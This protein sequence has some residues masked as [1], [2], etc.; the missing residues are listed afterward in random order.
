MKINPSQIQA[1]RNSIDPLRSPVN[2]TVPQGRKAERIGG[3]KA[4]SDIA[5]S[6][7]IDMLSRAEKQFLAERFNS[8]A[9]R[10]IQSSSEISRV[11]GR[12]LDINV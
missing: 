10:K 5:G 9:S 11:R 2:Q 6:K 1:Y 3:S 7:F 4:A 12:L 8:A